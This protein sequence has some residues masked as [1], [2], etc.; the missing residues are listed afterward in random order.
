LIDAA[1]EVA[2]LE[3]NADWTELQFDFDGQARAIDAAHV[4]YEQALDSFRRVHI[5][6][7][8]RS[9]CV[10]S[11]VIFR[12]SSSLRSRSIYMVFKASY[13]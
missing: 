6:P 11:V 9:P 7:L 8:V 1:A 13:S 10:C 3:R 4:T 12:V 5:E 2:R